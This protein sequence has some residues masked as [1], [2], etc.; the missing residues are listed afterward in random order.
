MKLGDNSFHISNNYW[1]NILTKEGEFMFEVTYVIDG[2]Q[3][4]MRV[5]AD[6]AIVAQSIF[7]NMFSGQK[8]E[9]IN[10]VRV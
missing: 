4:K 8:V 3:K 5:N 2:L 10:V 7:T 6:D 1:F 9:I